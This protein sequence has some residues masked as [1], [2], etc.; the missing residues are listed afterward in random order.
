[1]TPE[2]K[3]SL[4]SSEREEYVEYIFLASLCSH[5]WATDRFVEVSRSKTDAFG[6]DLVLS[7]GSVTRHIQLKASRVGGAA[8]SQK[9]NH[10]LTQKTGGC[11]VWI[12]VDSE[13]LVPRA[14]DWLDLPAGISLKDDLRGKVAKH[15]KANAQGVKNLRA[16][17]WEI[18]RTSFKSLAT[19]E[20]VFD[21]LFG[22]STSLPAG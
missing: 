7:S 10:A 17:I 1:V 16:N 8:R 14:F 6:Y 5:G 20:A 3:H 22:A 21:A 12:K 11:V 9:I 15:T 18:P 2:E 4:R 13:T 19:I